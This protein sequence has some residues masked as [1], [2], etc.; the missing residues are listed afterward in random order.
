MAAL[1]RPVITPVRIRAVRARER[2][3]PSWASKVLISSAV[4]SGWESRRT[5]PGVMVPSTS[6][7]RTFIC[8]ARF[9]TLAEIFVSV[10][11]K[12]APLYISGVDAKSARDGPR[13][14]R[15]LVIE[16]GRRVGLR[17]TYH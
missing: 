10:L 4:P 1:S 2:P 9:L 13:P 15:V 5:V 16:V 14:L 8:L 3:C 7:S 12:L 17:E 11:G 6:I